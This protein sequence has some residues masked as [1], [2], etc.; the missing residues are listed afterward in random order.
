M[1]NVL[2]IWTLAALA[3]VGLTSCDDDKLVDASHLPEAAQSFI[4]EH[5]DGARIS[6]VV[7]E[8]D[9]FTITYNTYLSDGTYVEFGKSGDWREVENRTAGV[10]T[11]IIPEK[12]NEYVATNYTS[13]FVVDIEREYIYNVELNNDLDLDFSLDGD[14]IRID[15]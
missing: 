9:D 15:N 7:K 8:H 5:F 1:K 6:S 14:F 11:T 10:P 4:E 3:V 12:I 13:L 2:K